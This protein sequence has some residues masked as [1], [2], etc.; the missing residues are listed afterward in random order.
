MIRMRLANPRGYRAPVEEF[1]VPISLAC[2]EEWRRHGAVLLV[3]RD[4]SWEKK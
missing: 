1:D 2:V 4:N 3:Q